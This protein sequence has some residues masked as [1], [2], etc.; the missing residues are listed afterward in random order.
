[1][2]DEPF[3]F[4]QTGQSLGQRFPFTAPLPGDPANKNLSFATYEPFTYYPGYNIHNVLP[5]AEHFNLSVQRELTKSTV[6]T[7]A[8][9]GTEG[10]HLIT[11]NEANPGSPALCQQLTAMGA[12]DVTAQSVGCGSFGENDVYQLPTATVPC[13]TA[14]PTPL[15]GCVYGTRS[16]LLTPNY[17]P[18]S[19]TLVCYGSNNTNTLTTA[20]SVYHSG[21]ISVERKANDLFIPRGIHLCQG[22]GRLFRFR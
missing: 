22:L 10:H 4:R 5:F 2:F 11:Q 19:V 20:N 8:Y 14:S 18:E 17:C 6:L 1:M 9:V 15:P 12:I 21:Q 3:R 16:G 7:L 13:S